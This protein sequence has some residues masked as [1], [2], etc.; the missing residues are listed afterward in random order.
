MALGERGVKKK[1]PRWCAWC[2]DDLHIDT[3]HFCDHRC[4]RAFWYDVYRTK[5]DPNVVAES[6]RAIRAG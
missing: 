5:E 3:T 1:K 4:E 6:L 2:G